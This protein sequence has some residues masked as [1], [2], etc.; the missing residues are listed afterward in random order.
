MMVLTAPWLA[1]RLAFAGAFGTG[2]VA[3]KVIDCSFMLTI[4]VMVM[5]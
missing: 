1:G 3:V 5:V 2:P 4:G